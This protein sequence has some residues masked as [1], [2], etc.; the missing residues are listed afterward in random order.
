[1]FT[2]KKSLLNG[3]KKCFPK[4]SVPRI[5]KVFDEMPRN[6]ISEV[7]KKELVKQYE[8]ENPTEKFSK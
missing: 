2:I 4:Q 1:M 5:I 3:V 7:N 8:K 6:H